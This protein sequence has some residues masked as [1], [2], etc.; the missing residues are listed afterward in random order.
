MFARLDSQKLHCDC[1]S[2]VELIVY[3]EW[4]IIRHANTE[5]HIKLHDFTKHTEHVDDFTEHVDDN[6][7]YWIDIDVDFATCTGARNT[8]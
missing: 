1:L 8:G 6:A 7:G 2:P 5:R 4:V 3:P